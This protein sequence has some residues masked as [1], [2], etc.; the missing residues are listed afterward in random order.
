[1]CG[2]SWVWQPSEI[3]KFSLVVGG[4]GDPSFLLPILLMLLALFRLQNVNRCCVLPSYFSHFPP[5]WIFRFQP[6]LLL[7]PE[8]SPQRFIWRS[9]SLVPLHLEVAVIFLWSM[10]NLSHLSCTCIRS[11]YFPN[12]EVQKYFERPG[13]KYRFSFSI[14]H[15]G[16]GEQRRLVESDKSDQGSRRRAERWMMRKRC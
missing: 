3:P 2:G 4:A 8:Y 13:A 7:P 10:R 14:C 12:L 1:M 6:P 16:R 9:H 15:L 11:F 5:P